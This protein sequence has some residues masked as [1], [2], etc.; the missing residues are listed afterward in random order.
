MISIIALLIG[1]LLPALAKARASGRLARCLANQH[2]LAIAWAMYADEQRSFP[3]VDK[4]D[5]HMK[6]RWGWGG[7]H[8]YGREA[9]GTPIDMPPWPGLPALVAA[10]PINPYVGTPPIVETAVGVYRCPGDTPLR[11]SRSGRAVDW[12]AFSQFS[13]SDEKETTVFGQLGTS[14]EA[15]TRLYVQAD[16][17]GPDP[18]GTNWFRRTMGPKDVHLPPSR[19]VLLGDIGGLA[20]ASWN[21]QSRAVSDIITG[22]WHGK[23]AA[24]LVFHDASTRLVPL[25]DDYP[26]DISFSRD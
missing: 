24:T 7:V 8:W 15:N 14:Y 20:A 3:T 21:R 12:S 2:Q 10:R 18:M 17:P 4:P 11:M 9:D 6:L 26:A 16:G 19:V 5:W 13:S 1:L 23:D 22:W 25:G